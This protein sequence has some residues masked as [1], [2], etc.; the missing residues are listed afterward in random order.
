MRVAN[1]TGHAIADVGIVVG[2]VFGAYRQLNRKKASEVTVNA[3]LLDLI[4]F[5]RSSHT[6]E[7]CGIPLVLDDTTGVS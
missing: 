1:L 7:N 4:F 3:M 6:K 5:P 2:I